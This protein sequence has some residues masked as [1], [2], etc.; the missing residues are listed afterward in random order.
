MRVGGMFFIISTLV[1]VASGM[2]I[3]YFL[4]IAW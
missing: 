3:K 2:E 1:A 4:N